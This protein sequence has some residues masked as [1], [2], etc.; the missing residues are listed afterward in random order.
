MA[1][2]A[3]ATPP[4][5]QPKNVLYLSGPHSERRGFFDTLFMMGLK[6]HSLYWDTP[7]DQE[8]NAFSNLIPVL[9]EGDALLK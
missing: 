5:L 6:S 3:P 4:P 9:Y 1:E 7:E 2:P 8:K